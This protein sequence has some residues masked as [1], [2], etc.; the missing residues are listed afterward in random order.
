VRKVLV[1]GGAGY[2][3]SHTMQVLKAQGYEQVCFDNLST[4]YREFVG[5]IPLIQGDLKN[6]ADLDAAFSRQDI[7]AVLHF[8]SHALVEESRRNPHKYYH[9]NILNTLNLLEAM[10]RHGVAFIVFSSSCAAYGVPGRVPIDE[11]MPL[12]P[13]QPYGVTKMVIE[14]ILRDYQNAYGLRFVSLRYFNAAGAAH[15]GSIGEWHVPESH[16]IPRLLEVALGNGT[17]A[18]IYGN[19]YPTP[20]GT[21]IRDY[22][23]VLDLAFAHA[24][25]LEYLFSGQASEILNLGTG[26]GFS[27]LQVVDRVK[28]IT[29][30]DLPIAIKTR[31]LGDPP[32]LVANA[33]KAKAKLG[34]SPRH[35]SLEEIVETAWNWRRGAPC[36][37]LAARGHA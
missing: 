5:D 30:K 32:K 17:C 31:R 7:A 29:G 10:R 34:W 27:V 13:V 6:A 22:V 14:H 4:G 1:T 23:H 9:D 2:V 36:R 15:D 8:A 24:A 35:S 12:D 3:G 19:D 33:G 21:C 11:G 18:E 16:L 20:D 37:A 25:A 28:K 26:H